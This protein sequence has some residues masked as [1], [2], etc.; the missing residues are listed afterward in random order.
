[1]WIVGTLLSLNNFLKNSKASKLMIL[2]CSENSQQLG[3]FLA[4]R[5][6]L[7]AFSHF[8]FDSVTD[9]ANKMRNTFNTNIK[10]AGIVKVVCVCVYGN[11]FWLMTA[12]LFYHPMIPE[13]K[14]KVLM[15]KLFFLLSSKLLIKL[16]RFAKNITMR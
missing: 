3:W 1:M 5:S 2:R 11:P 8:W 13:S 10:N 4:F 12:Y 14:V 7:I 15:C 16:F 9:K 6:I